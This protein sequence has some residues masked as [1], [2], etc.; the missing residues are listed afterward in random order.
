MKLTTR[1][2][3]AFTT[4]VMLAALTPFAIPATV[5]ARAQDNVNRQIEDGTRQCLREAR[6]DYTRCRR[7]AHGRN[8]LARCRRDYSQ[9]RSACS[10]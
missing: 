1:I 7:H 10:G 3:R 5:A 6:R 4:L 2:A 9:R 8:G